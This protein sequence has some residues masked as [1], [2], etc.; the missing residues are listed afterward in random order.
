MVFAEALGEMTHKRTQPYRL[1][2][3]GKVER[4]NQTM[5]QEWAYARPHRSEAERVAAFPEFLR[6]YNHHRGRTQG[7]FTSRPCTQ[8]LRAEQLGIGLVSAAL[9]VSASG[10]QPPKT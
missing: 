7:C 8:P 10:W 5:D 1:Q 2:T 9:V 3:N 6:T 4:F